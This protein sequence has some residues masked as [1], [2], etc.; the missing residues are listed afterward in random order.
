MQVETLSGLVA[1]TSLARMRPRTTADPKLVDRWIGEGKLPNL[2]A[3]RDSGVAELLPTVDA[4]VFDEAHQLVEA[5]V[6]FLGTVLGT[7]QVL[8]LAGDLLAS[9]KDR[10]EH[11]RGAGVIN[12]AR[13]IQPDIVINNR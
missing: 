11:E 4:A 5:A 1:T 2:A 8:H 13:A 7:G 9:E 12:M 10:R 3:L 6:Q